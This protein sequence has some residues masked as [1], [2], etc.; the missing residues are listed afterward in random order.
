MLE[1]VLTDAISLEI[2]I[3]KDMSIEYVNAIYEGVDKGVLLK[4]SNGYR[5]TN[6]GIDY[7]RVSS[8]RPHD[9]FKNAAHKKIT[10]NNKNPIINLVKNISLGEWA[11][12]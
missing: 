10:A 9:S 7:L 6:A 1:E 8:F 11:A 4:T 3:D 2:S 5:I 12:I